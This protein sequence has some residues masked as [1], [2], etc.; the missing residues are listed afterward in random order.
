M[1][2]AKMLASEALARRSVGVMCNA[3][4][5]ESG[6]ESATKEFKKDPKWGKANAGLSLIDRPLRPARGQR[7]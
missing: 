2:S 6:K 1:R 5:T 7:G 3:S 4:E